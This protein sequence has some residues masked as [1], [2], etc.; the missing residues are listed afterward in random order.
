MPF[1]FLEFRGPNPGSEWRRFGDGIRHYCALR[2]DS[3]TERTGERIV[4]GAI[5]VFDAMHQ[6]FR[7]AS[8]GAG[9][10]T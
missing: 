5:T 1:A 3:A 8:T 9:V 2:Q 4:E 10:S 7:D 6:A